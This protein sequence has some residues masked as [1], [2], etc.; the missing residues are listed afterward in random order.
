[1]TVVNQK[2]NMKDRDS[3][4]QEADHHAKM[5][6]STASLMTILQA[7]NTTVGIDAICSRRGPDLD[8]RRNSLLHT[9]ITYYTELPMKVLI[10]PHHLEN[11]YYTLLP[12]AITGNH[13]TPVA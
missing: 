1:M 11:R 4:L 8:Y 7:K 2:R 9:W 12:I 5:L 6:A 10:T 13:L 3:S